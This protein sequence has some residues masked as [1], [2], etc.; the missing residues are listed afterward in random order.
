MAGGVAGD[1]QV[2]SRLPRSGRLTVPL[3][4]AIRLCREIP[5]V[6]ALE[7][8]LEPKTGASQFD[9]G[10]ITPTLPHSYLIVSFVFKGDSLVVTANRVAWLYAAIWLDTDEL[11]MCGL[12]SV[13]PRHGY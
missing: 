6:A 10:I 8:N 13:D 2:S 11:A 12:D 7:G 3:E 9:P 4:T 5:P 1:P